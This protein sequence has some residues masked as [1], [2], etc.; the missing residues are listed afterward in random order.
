MSRVFSTSAR[1]I[2][3]LRWKL[4]GTTEDVNWANVCL[5]KP[6]SRVGK[7]HPWLTLKQPLL[8]SEARSGRG[9]NV[10]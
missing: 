4:N 3:E 2:K 10:S 1:R 9:K 8:T 6:P 7:A 5:T